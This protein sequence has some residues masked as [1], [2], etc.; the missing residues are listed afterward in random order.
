[1]LGRV[2]KYWFRDSDGN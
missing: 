1:M 2:Y